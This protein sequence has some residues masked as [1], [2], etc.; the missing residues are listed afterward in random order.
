MPESGHR[1]W[2]VV[3]GGKVRQVPVFAEL[4]RLIAD[5]APEERPALVVQLAARL[6]QLGAT[7]AA[8]SCGSEAADDAPDLNLPAKEAARRLGMSL[9]YL[10]KH[11]DEYPFTV[12]IGGR[13]LFSARG[14]AGWNRRKMAEKS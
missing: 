8:P 13:V 5:S 3:D 12:R 14:V 7:L 2:D 6:A 9:P 4:D 1:S 11:A 10:Y